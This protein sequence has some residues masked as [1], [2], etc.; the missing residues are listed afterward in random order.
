M[1]AQSGRIGERTGSSACHKKKVIFSDLASACLPGRLHTSAAANIR[2]LECELLLSCF[3]C[4]DI[5]S[6]TRSSPIL[7]TL[8]RFLGDTTGKYLP[9]L[10]TATI[11]AT[12]VKKSQRYTYKFASIRSL[13]FDSRD[14]SGSAQ[15]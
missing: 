6:N 14:M 8:F 7:R 5:S 2:I 13:T 9:D 4:H 11:I 10:K 3:G 12:V 1:A 15:L